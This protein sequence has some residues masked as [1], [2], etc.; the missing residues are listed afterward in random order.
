MEKD[1]VLCK[2]CM[3]NGIELCPMKKDWQNR[4]DGFCDVGEKE[5]PYLV[6]TLLVSSDMSTFI[7]IYDT[8]FDQCN[9]EILYKCM[10]TYHISTYCMS[11]DDLRRYRPVGVIRALKDKKVKID[12]SK[13]E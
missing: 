5:P 8:A 3:Y 2:D 10:D 1:V 4:P 7:L 9:Q 6:G 12:I 11:E 13:G